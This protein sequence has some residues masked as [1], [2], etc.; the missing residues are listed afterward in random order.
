MMSLAMLGTVAGTFHA[1]TLEVHAATKV[2][3]STTKK[4]INK[5]ASFNL[6]I[7]GVKSAKWS[8]SNKKV[9]TIKKVS[10]TKY[11]I[12]GKKAGSATIT[13][14]VGKKS[15]R[16][17]VTVETPK[18]SK[19]KLTLTAG[20]SETLKITGTKSKITWSTSNKNI[21]TVSKTGVVKG[22]KKGNVKITAKVNGK[23]ITCTI[24]VNAKPVSKPTATPK[25]TTTPKPTA[26][27]VPKPTVHTHSYGGWVV[28]TPATE[29]AEGMET[30]VCSCGKIETRSIPKLPSSNID[31]VIRAGVFTETAPRYRITICTTCQ[32]QFVTP[33]GLTAHRRLNEDQGDPTHT[34]STTVESQSQGYWSEQISSIKIGQLNTSNFSVKLLQQYATDLYYVATND[35]AFS[36]R[37]EKTWDLDDIGYTNPDTG[38]TLTYRDFQKYIA[39]IKPYIQELREIYS[40]VTIVNQ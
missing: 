31:L 19:T 10:N 39:T 25:P 29:Q 6:T 17:K 38:E 8:T 20:K 3:L 23:K 40:S 1:T 34:G 15:Y 26:T 18:I 22:I 37:Y 24:T 12:T 35:K 30:R 4:S 9:A 13:I 7:K 36:T 5:D 27:P 21:A 2:K 32:A 28:T 14:K 16:C 33:S 11:K